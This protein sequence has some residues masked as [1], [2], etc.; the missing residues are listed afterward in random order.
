M[1][2]GQGNIWGFVVAAT[3]AIFV[4]AILVYIV[5]GLLVPRITGTAKFSDCDI[6]SPGEYGMCVQSGFTCPTIQG[7]GLTGCPSDQLEEVLEKKFG[8][9]EIA[10]DY[11]QCCIATRCEDVSDTIDRKTTPRSCER[12]IADKT[13]C[14][15][16]ANNCFSKDC[17]VLG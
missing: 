16:F 9:K 15:G 14:V 13:L 8:D 2:K 1:I 5:G 3:V 17:C 4:I 7:R 10:E 6:G 12:D 11:T